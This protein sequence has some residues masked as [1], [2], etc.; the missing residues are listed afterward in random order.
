MGDVIFGSPGV[1]IIVKW[2]KVMQGSNKHQVVQLSSLSASPLCPVSAHKKLIS[3]IKV[4]SSF[5]LFLFPSPKGNF[6]IS[7]PMV[8][9]TLSKILISL[10]LNPAYYGFHALRRS[11]VSWAVDHNVPLQNLKAHGGW[12]S[13]AINAYLKHTPKASSTVATTFQ[14]N[15]QL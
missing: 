3:T 15:L 9:S 6:H 1:H 12:S 4:S 8:T 14:N 11:A 7:S 10:K 5:P 13:N 2:G